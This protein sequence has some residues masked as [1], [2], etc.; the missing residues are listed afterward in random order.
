MHH[1]NFQ[2]ASNA[3]VEDSGG[4]IAFNKQAEP[5]SVFLE[6]DKNKEHFVYQEERRCLYY[7][8]GHLCKF[9]HMACPSLHQCRLN[10]NGGARPH[11]SQTLPH[12]TSSYIS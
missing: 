11:Q 3:T 7:A 10:L 6:L 4:T 8:R 9:F 2:V 12:L 1:E 5:D